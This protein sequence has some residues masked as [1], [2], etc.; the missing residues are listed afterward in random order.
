MFFL[1]EKQDTP[2]QL[3]GKQVADARFMPCGPIG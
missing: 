3:K 2:K 1:K